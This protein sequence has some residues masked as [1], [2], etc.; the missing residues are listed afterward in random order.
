MNSPIVRIESLYKS[1][2]QPD[3]SYLKVIKGINLSINK[4]DIYFITGASGSGKSTLLHLIGSFDKPDSGKILY[5]GEDLSEFKKKRITKY[6]NSD[7][8][9]V[10]QFHY[11]MPELTVLENV[12]FPMLI[13]NFNKI[14]AEKKASV[15]L[16]KVGLG[17]KL[18]NM[19]YDLSG[20]ERQRAAIARSLVN[21]PKLLLADEPTGN[22]DSKTGEIVFNLF[23]ELIREEGLSAIIATHNENLIKKSP[24]RLNLV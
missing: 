6:R 8:G 14:A 5:N 3:D 7:I 11:L 17:T 15:L 18:K 16:K 1:F 9:F 10:Y 4:G 19:P 20:G 23:L 12:E 22:L 13:K 2:K 24:N 21:S